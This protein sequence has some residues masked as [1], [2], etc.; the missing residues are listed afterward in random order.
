MKIDVTYSTDDNYAM[1]TGISMYSLFYNN[2][3]VDELVVHLL[4]NKVSNINIGHFKSI[5]EQF[6]REV[7][8]YD[9][10]SLSII[11]ESKIKVKN[12]I[13]IAGYLRLFLG[14]F[15]PDDVKKILYMDGDSIVVGDVSTLFQEEMNDNYAMAVSGCAPHYVKEC[16]GLDKTDFYFNSGFILMNLE[17]I[18]KDNLE[19]QYPK[20]IEDI[21]PNSCYNDQDVINAIMKGKIMILHPKYNAMTIMYIKRTKEIKKLNNLLWY[22]SEHERREATKNPVFIH[23]IMG[24]PWVNNCSHPLRDMWLQYKN[25]SPWSN[26]PNLPDNR[27]RLSR[28]RYFL[29]R[30]LPACM[31]LKLDKALININRRIKKK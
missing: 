2:M 7:I 16:I 17:N 24:K 22:Y 25:L 1:Y 15:I 10:E 21:L 30:K 26:V 28:F 27:T 4:V 13:S 14:T 9:C 12:H 3:H 23:Y 8:Y 19:S 18:R 11:L 20:F 5:A 31:Y 6:N 29:Y